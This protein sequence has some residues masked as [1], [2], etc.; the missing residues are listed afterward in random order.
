MEPWAG[1]S[2]GYEETKVSPDP[3]NGETTPSQGCPFSWSICPSGCPCPI[4]KAGLGGGGTNETGDGVSPGEALGDSGIQVAA[5]TS[6]PPPVP[7]PFGRRRTPWTRQA[8]QLCLWAAGGRS[9]G[10]E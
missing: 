9:L 2:Q 5:R 7:I 1:A 10:M 4:R 3:R 6:H 8:L